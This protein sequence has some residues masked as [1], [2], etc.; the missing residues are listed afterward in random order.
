MTGILPD[1][2]VLVNYSLDL[3]EQRLNDGVL[4]LQ[5]NMGYTLL[6]F[7]PK[8]PARE[9][10]RRETY[11]QIPDASFNLCD[12]SV[13]ETIPDDL[14]VILSSA[15]QKFV[16]SCRSEPEKVKLL[17]YMSHKVRIVPSKLNS[18]LYSQI[19]RAHV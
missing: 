13:L 6:T 11:S 7:F 14:K 9:G 3:K 8:L 16:F 4:R 12:F 15:S 17:D 18:G 5:N 2:A 19:G 1:Q 10:D